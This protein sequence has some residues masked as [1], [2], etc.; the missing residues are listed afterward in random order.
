MASPDGDRRGRTAVAEATRPHARPGQG[1]ADEDRVQDFPAD[2]VATDPVTGADLHSVYD[3]F[4]VG[5]GY[6]D[7]W[8][9]LNNTDT[10][11]ATKRRSRLPHSTTARPRRWS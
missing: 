10:I 1:P 7:V 5:A 9:A 6:L 3:L 2:S 8:A 11:S 4:T